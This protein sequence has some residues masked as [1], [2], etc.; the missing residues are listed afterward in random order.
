[1]KLRSSTLTRVG[2]AAL[3]V[4]GLVQGGATVNAAAVNTAPQTVPALR[5]WTGGT[6][7]YKFSSAT[8]IVR[9][10]AAL[11][12]DSQTLADDLQKLSGYTITQ[13]SGTAAD[14]RA[15]DVF[16]GLGN[17]DGQLGAEGYALSITDRI[18][19][20]AGKEAGVFAG[21]RTVLQLLHQSFTVPQG[22]ARDWATY[23][24][25]G[26]MVDDGRKFFTASWLADH[27]KELA[28][29]KLNVLHLHLSDNLGFRIE[30]T[31]H[32]E[33][34]SA[35]H[36]TKQQVT[37]LVALAARYH[38]T[39][40]PEIDMP[41]HMDTIL[42]AHPDL[43][44]TGRDG[45][46]NNG[47]IDLSKDA[48]YPLMQDL[49]TEYLPLF[50]APYWHIG[51]DEYVRDYANYPQLLTYA[52]AHYGA[53]ATAKD[54]YYGF[55][56][57][58]DGL[59]RAGG[60]TTRMWNDGIASGDGTVAPNKDIT[61]EFW[62]NS[63]LSPQQ[64]VDAG[65]TVA[66][67]SWDPTYYVL[68]GAKPNTTWGYETWTPNV[69]QGSQTLTDPAR[70][71]GS[72]IHVWCDNPNAETEAQVAA[73]I[74]E[75]LR[76]L[77]QQL[78]GSPKPVPTWSAFT[79]VINAVGHNPAWPV[80]AQP[81]NLAFGKPASASSVE[82]A[83]FPAR[84]ATDGDYGTRWSSGYTD[85]EW[86]QVDL[87]A[88]TAIGRV[89][90]T[91]ETAYG[92]GYQ[93]QTSADG[94]TWTTIYS[95]TTGRGGTED[96]SGL[97]GTGRYVRMQGTQRATAWGFSLFEFEVYAPS[98]VNSGGTYEIVGAVS[99]K[100]MDNPASSTATGTQL[101]VWGVHG[102]TNQRWTFTANGDGTYSVRNA[103]S[104]L[105]VDVNGGSQSAGAAIIQWT[106]TGTSN[107]RW[108][109]VAVAAGGYALVAQ[110]SGLAITAASGADGALLTQQPNTGADNQRWTMISTQ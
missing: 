64:L 90:L 21:T 74:R 102:G 95:T 44:L 14:L 70:N 96:L 93:I 36:L 16:L 3:V 51:A 105:C 29:L 103:A 27:V 84:N 47:F 6:G 85:R 13:V 39:V 45:T 42:A 72:L 109:P 1:M 35:D 4:A 86:L 97:S 88:S 19:I 57:W 48:A 10:T 11:A 50:P 62:I 41:G 5:E 100:A 76:M 108:T 110:S 8:R 23:P 34:V 15:G 17:S 30:S 83:A 98:P 71:R 106:C 25:R 67:E 81:G 89:K 92:K 91:W 77:A 26:L 37:D 43:K 61:V 104:Q 7:S 55:V 31:K 40:V 12:G 38:V 78:W 53:N 49:I 99:G 60:K 82:T 18:T 28:Y 24:E 66:N 75:P 65:H 20:S 56:N 33:F 107:Q 46:V 73:G 2:L 58:A 63:G 54:T 87:G 59:V 80:T 68:G 94:T 22:S 52:R 69:F 32:P 101:I 79:G 9:G